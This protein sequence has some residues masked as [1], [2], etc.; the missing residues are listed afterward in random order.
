MKICLLGNINSVHLRRWATQLNKRGHKIDVIS[1]EKSI[2]LEN[3]KIYY[4]KRKIPTKLNYIFNILTV[5]KLINS[6]DPDIVHAH[7]LTSYGFIA[8]CTGFCPLVVSAWGSD[9]LIS[10][11]KNLLLKLFVRFT[12]KK[13]CLIHS[14]ANFVEKNLI[15]LG[16]KPNQIVVLPFGIDKSLM[17]QIGSKKFKEPT[18]LIIISTRSL[19]YIYNVE[20]LIKS[21]P[22]IIKKY[23]T[24]ECLIIG[25]GSQRKKLEELSRNLGVKNNVKFLGNLPHNQLLEQLKRADIFIS[26]SFSDMNNVSLNEAMACGSFPVCTDIPANREWIKDEINGFLVPTNSPFILAQKITEAYQNKQ[27]I[28]DAKK[29]N[30][31]IIHERA[32]LDDNVLKME[33]FYEKVIS[34]YKTTC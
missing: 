23:D 33:K 31:E 10:P 30:L 28:N 24:L 15:D 25:D 3:I 8:A 26:T 2:P 27:L 4:I 13:A 6:I 16:A 34:L 5:K 19:D 18:N 32:I 12:I 7:Y 17:E 1:F 29:I 20:L 21:L 14:L 11:Q 9:V 22:Y